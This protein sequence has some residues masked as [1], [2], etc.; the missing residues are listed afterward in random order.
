MIN[1]VDRKALEQHRRAIAKLT[2]K[3]TSSGIRQT[4]EKVSA[5]QKVTNY[6]G[7][8]K[9]CGEPFYEGFAVR[10]SICKGSIFHPGCFGTHNIMVHSPTSVTV[11][12]MESGVEN[13]WKYVDA[14]PEEIEGPEPEIVKEQPVVEIEPE[15]TVE[16]VPEEEEPAVVATV[17]ASPKKAVRSKKRTQ[18]TE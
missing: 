18:P 14:E 1:M 15:L 16:E 12:V 2:P 11:I 7:N 4:F 9:V 17:E 8:C 5:G 10:C 13:V 6:R 3:G